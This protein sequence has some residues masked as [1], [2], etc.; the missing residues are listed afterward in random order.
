MRHLA[1][2]QIFPL[3]CAAIEMEKVY[4]T[5]WKYPLSWIALIPVKVIKKV[6]TTNN[7]ITPI[8]LMIWIIKKY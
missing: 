3:H 7:V 4:G 2:L 8:K 6:G 1:L 5:D